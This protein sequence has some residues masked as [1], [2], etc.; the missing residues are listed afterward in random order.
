MLDLNLQMTFCLT[1]AADMLARLNG[2][3]TLMN[4]LNALYLYYLIP[5]FTTTIDVIVLMCLM[6]KFA[7][8]STSYTN[9]L[10]DTALKDNNF[11]YLTEDPVTK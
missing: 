5:V 2:C 6:T 1:D 9:D 8:M 10:Q 4:M 3:M 11:Q 7:N